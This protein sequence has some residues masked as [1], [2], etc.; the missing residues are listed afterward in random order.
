[1]AGNRPYRHAARDQRPLS[2][3]SGGAGPDAC[4]GDLYVFRGRRGDLIK[5]LWRDAL[6]ASLYIKRLERGRFLWPTPGEGAIAIPASRMG[7]L[8]EGI[9]WRHPQTA[10]RP[11]SA[12]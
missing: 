10:W 7:Y 1:M 2:D 11:R 8:L 6:G 4:S 3:G 12:G 5:V 9:D